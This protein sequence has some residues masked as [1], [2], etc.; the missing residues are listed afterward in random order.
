MTA[1]MQKGEKPRENKRAVQKV[2]FFSIA[3][4]E[5]QWSACKLQ[6]FIIYVTHREVVIW[7]LQERHSS[8]ENGFP[9][10]QV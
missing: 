10:K 2:Q 6:L 4:N 9:G 1:E 5:R 3:L 8:Q 7:W